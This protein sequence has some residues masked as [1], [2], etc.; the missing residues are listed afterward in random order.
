MNVSEKA[1]LP[2]PRSVNKGAAQKTNVL[3]I[4]FNLPAALTASSPDNTSR[5]RDHSNA[6]A[7]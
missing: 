6:F 3:S 2:H 7:S 4:Q 1:I 5:A